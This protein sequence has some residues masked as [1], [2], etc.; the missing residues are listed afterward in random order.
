MARAILASHSNY[1]SQI[2]L[3]SK[4]E[5]GATHVSD[6][7]YVVSINTQVTTSSTTPYPSP[8]RQLRWYFSSQASQILSKSR[9]RQPTLT[10]RILITTSVRVPRSFLGM[11]LQG[12][13]G[14]LCVLSNSTRVSKPN[15]RWSRHPSPRRN[16]GISSQ[17][18][19]YG[20]RPLHC[21]CSPCFFTPSSTYGLWQ[22]TLRWS[23]LWGNA[24]RTKY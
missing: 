13:E 12:P 6:K 14:T 8:K 15:S 4:L 21:P 16:T 3:N 7:S 11:R 24:F 18:P 10:C 22:A 23:L 1:F 20:D 9:W 5:G 2:S 19:M 17:Y